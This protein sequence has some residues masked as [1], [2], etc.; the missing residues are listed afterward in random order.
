MDNMKNFD[1]LAVYRL[2]YELTKRVY[3]LTTKLPT[4]EKYGLSSQMR[5]CAVSIPSNIA[6]GC[7]RA[8]TKEFIHYLRIAKGSTNELSVQINLT[9]DIYEI[10]DEELLKDLDKLG[11]MLFSFIKSLEG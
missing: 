5:R 1:D 11:R 9:K 6:E 4:E 8:S 2:G 10:S 3:L 7:S